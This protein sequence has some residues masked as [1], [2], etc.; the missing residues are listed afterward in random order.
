MKKFLSLPLFAM[1]AAPGL[2]GCGQKSPFVPAGFNRAQA[3]VVSS[4]NVV[5]DMSSQSGVGQVIRSKYDPNQQLNYGF[6][7]LEL[8]YQ[9]YAQPGTTTL[10]L[11][12]N[13]QTQTGWIIMVTAQGTA[14]EQRQQFDLSHKQKVSELNTFLSR[15]MASN[16]NDKMSLGYLLQRLGEALG[17]DP[18]TPMSRNGNG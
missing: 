14:V 6:E 1:L 8:V 5:Q 18:L 15:L 9:D 2:V 12:Y 3:P 11:S 7:H 17:Q 13:V 4:Q 16:I 10:N